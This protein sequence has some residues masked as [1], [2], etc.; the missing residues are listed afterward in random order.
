MLRLLDFERC[1][2]VAA[3]SASPGFSGANV[4]LIQTGIM[5]VARGARVLW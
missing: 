5:R 2:G 4:F 1:P 3:R